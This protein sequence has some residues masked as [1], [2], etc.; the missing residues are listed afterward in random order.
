MKMCKVG[1]I[2]LK[3]EAGHSCRSYLIEIS[4]LLSLNVLHTYL[5]INQKLLYKMSQRLYSKYLNSC[6][7]FFSLFFLLF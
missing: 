1:Q 6:Q 5:D 7:Q 4:S 3:R 2:E